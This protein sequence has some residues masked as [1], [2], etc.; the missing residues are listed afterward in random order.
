MA[1]NNP[2]VGTWISSHTSVDSTDPV[3][4]LEV[5]QEG[6]SDSSCTAIAHVLLR[7]E[8]HK[9]VSVNIEIIWLNKP[10][11]AR[12]QFFFSGKGLVGS[13]DNQTLV[14]F[15]GWGS[16]TTNPNLMTVNGGVADCTQP[17]GGTV[18]TPGTRDFDAVFRRK[19]V[20][21]SGSTPPTTTMPP[22]AG[23]GNPKCYFFKADKYVRFDV[24]TN[25]IDPGYP[26]SIA[27]DWPGM[28]E[29]GFDRDLDAA[30]YWADQILYFFKGDKFVLFDLAANK[31]KEP[32]PVPINSP[33]NWNGMP[34]VG[35]GDKLDTAVNWAPGNLYFFKGNKFLQYD[36]RANRTKG[37]VAPIA[38]PGNWQGMDASGFASDLDASLNWGGGLLYFFKG[39]HYI[40]FNQS[41]NRIDGGPVPIHSEGNWTG[42]Y[43]V[44]FGSNI[45]AATRLGGADRPVQKATPVRA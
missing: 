44:G 40:K 25:K 23:P 24:A 5:L 4:R 10:N 17:L 42:L 29:A 38:S 45:D 30:V 27:T 37:Q 2:L 39:D 35:F 3:L 19:E 18:A 14:A 34:S 36:S 43:E 9:D 33:E 41:N 15:V 6:A 32:A 20:A 28:K 21:S 16:V 7:S 26:R 11:E 12:D 8:D 22:P 1:I 31:V 13:G